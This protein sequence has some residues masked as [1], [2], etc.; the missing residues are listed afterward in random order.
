MN[1]KEEVCKSNSFSSDFKLNCNGKVLS[2]AKPVVMGILNITPDSFYDG[3]RYLTEKDYV[4]QAERMLSEG[5]AIIDVGA[6]ST[7][8]GA[9]RVP[10]DEELQRLLPAL[11][12]LRR[13]FKEAIFSVDTYWSEVALK[14]VEAGADM[15]NDITGGNNDEKMYETMATLALPYIMMHIQGTPAIMQ[16][17]P[18]YENV[19]GEI[20]SFFSERLQVLQEMGVK[21]VII[22]PGFGFGKTVSH[23]YELLCRLNEFTHLGVPVM[24]GLSRKSM[25]NKVLQTLPSQALNGT[26]VLNT[27]AILKEVNILR[28]HD[29]K[30]AVEVIRLC[31]QVL[32]F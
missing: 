29:V 28:V 18:S 25:I 19:V 24:A 23:N 8:P 5:A 6:V 7:R 2:L 9:A 21:D 27:I 14:A 12:T 10:P 1:Q 15:I 31:E 20:M 13:H 30:E 32:R 22:D 4:A 26:T 16:D 3:G 17:H 11:T